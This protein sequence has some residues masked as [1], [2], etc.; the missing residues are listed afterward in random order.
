M[1]GGAVSSQCRSATPSVQ[2]MLAYLAMLLLHAVVPQ[3]E[4]VRCKDDPETLYRFC[5]QVRSAPLLGPY[6]KV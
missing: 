6:F 1:F 2:S 4:A 3:A 5:Q